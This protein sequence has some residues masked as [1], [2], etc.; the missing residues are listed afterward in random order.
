MFIARDFIRCLLEVD[1]TKRMSLTHALRHPWLDSSGAGGSGTSHS[2]TT[3]GR[4]Y[5]LSDISELSE[6]PEDDH[7]IGA[8]GDASMLSVAPSSDCIPSVGLLNINTPAKAHARRP[9]ERR[10]KV[11]AREAE[12]EAQAV[13][14]EAEAEPATSGST[15]PSVNRNNGNAGKRRRPENS[16]GGSPADVAMGGESADSDEAAMDVEPQPPAAK[17]GRRSQAQGKQQNAASAPPTERNGSGSG[18]GRVLRSRAAGPASG[19]RR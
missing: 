4:H 2:F 17:R 1:P 9:L 15:P 3:M 19:S 5:S 6:F 8:N 18:S 14:K 11:L 10:S 12:A 16:A 13:S 7:D